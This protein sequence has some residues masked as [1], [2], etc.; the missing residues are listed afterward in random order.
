MK[1][2]ELSAEERYELRIA[3]QLHDCGKVVTPVHV[4]DKAT[5]LETIFDRIE[6][7]K[8]R[9]AVL[10]RDARLSAL[11]AELAR[12]GADPQGV[13]ASPE[14]VRA[15]RVLWA[16]WEFLRRCNVGVEFMSE[17]HRER[18]LDLADKHRWRDFDGAEQRLLSPIEAANLGIVKGTLNDEER[19]IINYHATATIRLLEELPFPKHMKNVPAIA[20]SHHERMDG[21]GYPNRLHRHQISMQGRILGLADVFEAL[22]AK[23]RPYK[24]GRTLTESLDI[25][26]RMRDEGH[27]DPDL[28]ELFVRERLYL[29]YAVDYLGPEQIDEAHHEEFE[30]LTSGLE[31]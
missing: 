25:L 30:R 31:I 29:R 24:P 18:V 11:S 15:L 2:F 27:I 22:T 14:L 23:D 7:V 8:L 6:L 12:R 28:H 4:M 21:E 13:L 26:E 1:D 20:G 3:A 10:E 17:E 9:F 16:D 19:E 5:K